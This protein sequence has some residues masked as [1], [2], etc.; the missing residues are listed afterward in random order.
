MAFQIFIEEWKKGNSF[1]YYKYPDNKLIEHNK[2]NLYALYPSILIF[3]G[4]LVLSSG[5]LVPPIADHFT[6]GT[7]P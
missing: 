2:T 4:G 5:L 3:Q 7:F 6:T 1:A